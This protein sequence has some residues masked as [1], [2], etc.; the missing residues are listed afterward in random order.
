MHLQRHSYL[1]VLA[2]TVS[3]VV[4]CGAAEQ[5]RLKMQSV[6]NMKM[7]LIA[8][9]NYEKVNEQWPDKVADI[10][11][12]LEN[13]VDMY[14]TNPVT[15]ENPGYEYVKPEGEAGSDTIVLYQ[16][17]DGKRDTELPVGYADGSVRKIGE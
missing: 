17:R 8:M 13:N 3:L 7:L 14:V 10:H 16:L 4:G 15:G 1:L 12:Q 6:N 11:D 2:I 9:L 5:A